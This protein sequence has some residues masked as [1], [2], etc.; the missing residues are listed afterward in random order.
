MGLFKKQTTREKEIDKAQKFVKT[1]IDKY[2]PKNYNQLELMPRLFQDNIHHM[3]SISSRTDGK[4]FNYLGCIM[5]LT[6]NFNIKFQL[7]VRHYTLRKEMF[8]TLL[9]I[10]T[11]IEYFDPKQLSIQNGDFYIIVFYGEKV[12]GIITDIDHV[13]DLKYSSNFLCDFKLVIYDEFLARKSDYLPDEHTNL[14]NLIESI[15]RDFEPDETALLTHPK[16]LYLGNA[17]NFDSPLLAYY[18]MFSV[19][20]KHKIN[21]LRDYVNGELPVK[22]SLE[23]RRNDKNN[24][25]RN[26]GIFPD[27]DDD[28]M[29]T[30]EFNFNSYALADDS[31]RNAVKNG[32]YY[33]FNIKL[34]EYY[35]NVRYNYQRDIYILSVRAGA[36]NYQFCTEVS[37]VKDGVIYLTEAY[38]S[39]RMHKKHVNGEFTYNDAFTKNY[40]TT[41][42]NYVQLKLFKLIGIHYEE[43]KKEEIAVRN[44]RMFKDQYE[45]NTKKSIMKKFFTMY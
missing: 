45:E 2:V 18:D 41:Q 21:T 36:E 27:E 17:V 35:L 28:A 11:T 37:D 12:I 32:N 26:I 14:K 10:A 8:N 42:E 38:Y 33:E 23:M 19:L 1:Y 25:K 20:E 43:N 22:L 9:K 44:E 30:G 5:A 40:I 16:I 7:I 6:I 34:L 3:M 13:S 15:N 29:S 4:T 24:A 31:V 39:E